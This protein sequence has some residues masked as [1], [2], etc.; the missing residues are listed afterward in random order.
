M[1]GR[2]KCEPLDSNQRVLERLYACTYPSLSACRLSRCG[3]GHEKATWHVCWHVATLSQPNRVIHCFSR[4]VRSN[5]ELFLN[6][7]SP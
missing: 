1:R 2:Q 7:D 5:F 6:R 3:T 4:P